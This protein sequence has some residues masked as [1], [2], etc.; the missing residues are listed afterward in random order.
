MN[1]DFESIKEDFEEPIPVFKSWNGWY[2]LVLSTLV[3][4]IGL[5]Y[6]FTISFD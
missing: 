1:K 5:F 3:I 4:L 2:A 6:L